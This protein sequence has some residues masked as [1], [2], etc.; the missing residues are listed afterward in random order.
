MAL[1]RN[2]NTSTD[3][4]DPMSSIVNMTDVMLVLAVGFM[5]FAITSTGMASILFSDMTLEQK[6]QAMDTAKQ[7]TEL[8]QTQQLNTTPENVSSSGS[9]YSEMGKV[10]QDPKTGKMVM[11][12]N[13]T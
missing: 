6:Q 8:E 9:G 4:H 11:V 13:N 12:Q 1:R 10:Y 2:T 3:E 5:I 7:T